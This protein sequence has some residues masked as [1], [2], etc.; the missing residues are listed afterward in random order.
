GQSGA[1]TNLRTAL[2]D[3]VI[4]LP[5]SSVITVR[6]TLQLNPR[7]VSVDIWDLRDIAL[8]EPSYEP[9]IDELIRVGALCMGEFLEGF[10]LRDC[11]EFDAWQLAAGDQ[12]RQQMSVVLNRLIGVNLANGDCERAVAPALRL[13]ALDPLEESSHRLAIEVYARCAKWAAAWSQF[14]QCRELLTE[15][16]G[17]DPAEE[18][19]RLA[20]SVREHTIPREAGFFQFPHSRS[21]QR[22]PIPSTRF[23]GRNAVLEQLR[24]LVRSG[25]RVIT[26]TGSAGI[27]KTRLAIETTRGL[28]GAF[29]GGT[30][31]VDLT[32]TSVAS[33]VPRLIAQ[34]IGVQQRF[35]NE[36]DLLEALA[37]QLDR[38]AVLLVLD[39]FEHVISAAGVVGQLVRRTETVQVLVTSRELL[40]I[41]G[42][43]QLRIMPLEISAQTTF[44][45]VVRSPAPQLFEDRARVH[46]PDFTI[47]QENFEAVRAICVALDGV[48]L[49]LELAVPLL[50][51]FTLEELPKLLAE[52]LRYLTHGKRDAAGRHRTLETSISWS[53]DLLSREEQR[54]LL[55]LS[56]FAAPFDLKAVEAVCGNDSQTDPSEIIYSLLNKSF[57]QLVEDS[58]SRRFGLLQA[59]REYALK[60]RDILP[61]LSEVMTRH[62]RYY[63]DLTLRAEKELHGA[64]QI[65][66]INRMSVDHPN[67][68]AS[69]SF[70]RDHRRTCS[71]LGM[72]VAL[73]WFWYRRGHHGLARRWLRELVP[74]SNDCPSELQARA[75]HSLGWFS[76]IVGEWRD[77][78]SLYI[79]SLRISRQIGDRTAESYAL[80]DLGVVERWLGNASKGDGLTE[81]AVR[82]ARL[83]GSP[84]VLTRALIWAYAT[85]G[86]VFRDCFPEPQLFEARRLA[87]ETGDLWL[88]AHSYNGLGDLYCEYGRYADAR[89]NYEAALQ[90][91]NELEDRMLAAWTLE[92]LGRVEAG[93][94]DSVS[95]L[96]QTARALYLFDELG[97]ELNV[98]LMMARIAATLYKL[99]PNS[100][101]A[102]IAGAAAT[103]IGR[104]RRD[105]LRRAPQIEEASRHISRFENSCPAEW[106]RGQSLSRADA[107]NLIRE[108]ITQLTRSA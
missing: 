86:G 9:S 45:A 88:L 99:E 79:S 62:A 4:R 15:E 29:P 21:Y 96:R 95:G 85:T 33:E 63:Y 83:S 44:D 78:R 41:E 77:A 105:E 8:C 102:Q 43:R 60:R 55:E 19:V 73:S 14:E 98:G 97:E 7:S 25:A 20:E 90:Q 1:R 46:R 16:L 84:A 6:D 66:W 13:V 24:T 80:S 104:G 32:S 12:I 72:A 51:M 71:A 92:G 52:P 68:L 108:R 89:A 36:A 27:G 74:L 50:G 10:T 107:V 64:D 76:F 5:D 23:F 59:T 37:Y 11:R 94:G 106:L 26:V 82:L 39:N 69:L 22:L 53:Y 17:T 18:T 54:L 42:E 93:C 57:I 75:I 47:S 61:C 35:D 3:A 100:S 67:I 28:D 30:V 81:A 56:V 65:Q 40:N 70:L 91:F 48:P 87:I 58:P 38:R 103:L 2:H 49:A 101:C 34:A 31:F